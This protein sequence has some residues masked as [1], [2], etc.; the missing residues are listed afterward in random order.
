MLGERLP[1]QL[2][3][4]VEAG[5]ELAEAAREAIAAGVLGY[6]VLIARRRDPA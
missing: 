6:G 5:L 2:V 1:E 3:G 4:K